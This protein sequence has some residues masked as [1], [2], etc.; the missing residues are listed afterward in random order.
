MLQWLTSSGMQPNFR[1]TAT[2]T[3]LAVLSGALLVAVATIIVRSLGASNRRAAWPQVL[4]LCWLLVPIALSLLESAAGQPIMLARNSIV[5]LPAVALLLAWGLT[6]RRVPY[7]LGWS[8]VG[9]LLVLR[10]LQLAPSYGASPENWKAGTSYVVE[11][12]LPG[13]CIAFYP[14][15]GRMAFD[16]YLGAGT[17]RAPRPVLPATPWSEVKPF[18]EDY[19][20]PSGSQLSAIETACPRLWFVASH[21]GLRDGPSASRVNYFRYRSLL[22]SLTSAYPRHGSV[23][24]GWASPVRVELLAR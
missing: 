6:H 7:W 12:A 22:G 14:S 15:D 11:R 13:D 8:A 4:V 2:S 3:P 19:R 17:A 20:S 5:S 9:A 21:Q 24:F 16:Y 1:P 18:V 10:G 23:S